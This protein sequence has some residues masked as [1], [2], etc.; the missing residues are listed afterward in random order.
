LAKVQYYAFGVLS[1][2][3]DVHATIEDARV[4]VKIG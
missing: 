3:E 4:G 1:A 2:D